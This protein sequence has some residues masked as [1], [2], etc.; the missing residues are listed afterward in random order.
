MQL[1]YSTISVP[2]GGAVTRPAG[3]DFGAVMAV[4]TALGADVELLA[5]VLPDVEAAILSD[6][7]D[8][9]GGDTPAQ[10]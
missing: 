3:L 10:S 9:D 7:S 1:R 6:Q 8:D 5:Q 4:G 2:M